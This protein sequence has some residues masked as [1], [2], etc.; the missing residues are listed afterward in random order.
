M[1]SYWVKTP[2]WLRLLFPKNIVWS[3]PP[4][5]NPAVFLTFDDGPHPEITPFVLSQLAL[6]NAKATFFCVG[7]NVVKYPDVYQQIIDQGHTVGNHTHH[8]LNGWKTPA[9]QYIRDYNKAQTVIKTLAFRPP[10]GRFTLGQYRKLVQANPQIKIYMWDI[11]SGDFD[12]GISPQ[13]CADNILEHLAPGSILVMHDSEKA[14]N[15]M[16][17]SL[18]LVL[19]YCN[20]KQWAMHALPQ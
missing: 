19:Q 12:Q 18:P 4:T 3:M 1:G 11:I 20:E 16:R 8:H 17:F 10:Y 5:A 14:W 9:D 13:Q 7:N 2:T 6:Y 15:N